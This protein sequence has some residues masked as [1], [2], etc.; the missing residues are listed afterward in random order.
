MCRIEKQRGNVIFRMYTTLCSG[1]T[2]RRKKRKK[3]HDDVDE[4]VQ[5]MVILRAVS[6]DNWT[7]FSCLKTFQLSSMKRLPNAVTSPVAYDTAL[8]ITWTWT[9]TKT[10]NLHQHL[11]LITL[12]WMWSIILTCLLAPKRSLCLPLCKTAEGCFQLLL[13]F[14]SQSYN[15]VDGVSNIS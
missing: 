8:R 2:V 14:V 3:K 4:V 5:V 11:S 1:C 7:C 9:R 12:F 15:S 13:R 10:E 6:F